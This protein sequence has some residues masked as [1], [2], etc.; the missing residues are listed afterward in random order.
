M[1]SRPQLRS[2]SSRGDRRGRGVGGGVACGNQG[3]KRTKA[4][5]LKNVWSRFSHLQRW[6]LQGHYSLLLFIP[7]AR[8]QSCEE[9]FGGFNSVVV[10]LN[11]W[12]QSLSQ[13]P[14]STNTWVT[15]S[16][17]AGA[18]PAAL[19]P[20]FFFLFWVIVRIFHH[21]QYCL[22]KGGKRDQ[23]NWEIIQ[24]DGW[25]FAGRVHHCGFGTA[26][27]NSWLKASTKLC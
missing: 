13:Y 12:I 14:L 6:P 3:L 25:H 27:S 11:S 2:R 26:V 22:P 18:Q 5:L 17:V 8:T 9:G 10:L 15:G 16:Q 21:C 20:I 7:G 4:V 1:T 19:L 23:S 24:R